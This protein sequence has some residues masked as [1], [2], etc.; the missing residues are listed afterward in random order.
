MTTKFK[1]K[2][3]TL[4][5]SI[6]IFFIHFKIDY[7]CICTLGILKIEKGG[8]LFIQNSKPPISSSSHSSFSF[9]FLILPLQP[10]PFSPF[11]TTF[12]ILFLPFP[13]SFLPT[14][15]F[16]PLSPSINPSSFRSTFQDSWIFYPF[17]RETQFWFYFLSYN[18]RIV[19]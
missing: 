12:F 8:E 3:F 17:S 18:T 5:S 13:P 9:F 7:I 16:I 2:K 11:R 19:E 14:S 4:P 10:S 15:F 6:S 1:N